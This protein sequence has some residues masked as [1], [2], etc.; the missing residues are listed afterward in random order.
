M[1]AQVIY[2]DF[3]KSETTEFVRKARQII[4]DFRKQQEDF[5]GCYIVRSLR[6]VLPADFQP[7][8]R[9][10]N[11]FG[12]TELERMNYLLEKTDKILFGGK[13]LRSIIDD[14]Y[15]KKQGSKGVLQIIDRFIKWTDLDQ[16]K[17]ETWKTNTQSF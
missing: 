13:Y 10:Y 6:T 16:Y 14:E 7:I 5:G 9:T 15:D 8:H 1:T 4:A 17:E 12:M 11:G 2:V 3:N